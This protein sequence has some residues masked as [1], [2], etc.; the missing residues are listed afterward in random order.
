MP[1]YDQYLADKNKF[2]KEINKVKNE[3]KKSP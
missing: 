3:N 1:K 2:Q